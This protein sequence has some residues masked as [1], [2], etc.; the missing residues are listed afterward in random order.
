[1]RLNRLCGARDVGVRR[2]TSLDS[3]YV[4]VKRSV[5]VN[6]GE[7]EQHGNAKALQNTGINDTIRKWQQRLLGVCSDVLGYPY[8][9]GHCGVDVQGIM[10]D[11]DLNFEEKKTLI[12]VE[13]V[14]LVLG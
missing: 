7:T 13:S 12:C 3:P 2:A 11:I 10:L 1:L 4:L 9:A 6:V 8:P 14:L 5:Y